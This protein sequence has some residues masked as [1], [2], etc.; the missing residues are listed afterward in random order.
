[1]ILLCNYMYKSAFL[2]LSYEG[3]RERFLKVHIPDENNK[4]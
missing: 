3:L 2:L 1:M 4:Q